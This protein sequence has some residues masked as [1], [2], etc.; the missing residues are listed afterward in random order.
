MGVLFVA[1]GVV[2]LFA[3][4]HFTIQQSGFLRRCSETKAVVIDFVSDDEADFPVFQFVE[5]KTGTT[6]TAKGWVGSSPPAYSIGQ[7]VSILYDPENPSADV[8]VNTFFGIWFASLICLGV[9]S[10]MT[11]VGVYLCLRKE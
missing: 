6:V 2:S 5:S 10:V 9:G 11:L 7:E 4:A 3:G 8:T 1:I